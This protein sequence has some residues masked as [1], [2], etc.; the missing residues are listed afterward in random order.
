M[1]VS[2]RSVKETC[3]VCVPLND[4][5]GRV[6]LGIAVPDTLNGMGSR[7]DVFDRVRAIFIGYIMS[8]AHVKTK[9]TRRERAVKSVARKA[10]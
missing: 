9:S 10:T 1:F 7:V 2:G 5:G 8:R 3:S 4:W 6:E